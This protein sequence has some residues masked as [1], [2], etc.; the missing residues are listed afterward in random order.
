MRR[1]PRQP[2]SG[3]FGRAM[4]NPRSRV[5]PGGQH[6]DKRHVISIAVTP[7]HAV[8][9][10][11]GEEVVTEAIDPGYAVGTPINRLGAARVVGHREWVMTIEVTEP[12]DRCDDPFTRRRD[13]GGPVVADLEPL[14]LEASVQAR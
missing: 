9:R 3:R 4:W 6:A 5:K 1:L 10:E 13:I 8:S 11:A 14:G 2:W 12:L 7:E